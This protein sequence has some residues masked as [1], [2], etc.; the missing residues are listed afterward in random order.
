MTAVITGD[1]FR[2]CNS[3]F[4][5]AE[6]DESEAARIIASPAGILHERRLAGREISHR[7][8]AEPSGRS[9]DIHALSDRELGARALHVPPERIRI[10]SDALRI[11]DAPPAVAQRL[12]VAPVSRVR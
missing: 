1:P 10:G 6:A 2:S 11:D 12:H 5:R 4:E 3:L 7:T 8:V 9:I